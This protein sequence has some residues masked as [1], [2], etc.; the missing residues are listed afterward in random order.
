MGAQYEVGGNVSGLQ[1]LASDQQSYIG[2]FNGILNEINSAAKD[3][4]SKWDGGSSEGYSKQH[5]EY[6]AHFTQ[7]QSAFNKLVSATDGA[8]SNYSA[9]M[10]KLNGLFGG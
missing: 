7:V 10:G 1:N 4:L 3:T 8:A 6:D 9:L 2:R 5:Q